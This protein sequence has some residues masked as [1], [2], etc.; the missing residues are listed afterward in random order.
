MIARERIEQ[1]TLMALTALLLLVLAFYLA[2][3]PQWNKL[4]RVQGDSAKTIAE[5]DK[6][7][8][9]VGMLPLIR[10]QCKTL[11]T[12]VAEQEQAFVG[13]G[14]FDGFWE[15]IKRCADQTG[16]QLANVRQRTDVRLQRSSSYAEQWIVLDTVAPYHV[17]GKWIDA[18]E[19]VSPFVR[20]IS[21]KVRSDE[22]TRGNHQAEI[23]VSFLTR[24]AAP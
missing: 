12:S 11:E 16:L 15:V 21:I 17:I 14:T 5:L 4:Q 19:R 6:A 20:I 8:Q 7:R 9:H 24:S 13:N 18:M 2:L 22:Q 23:T 3:L 1:I 10:Q